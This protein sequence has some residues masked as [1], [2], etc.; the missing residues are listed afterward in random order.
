[1]TLRAL[2]LLSGTLLAL[3][4][5]MFYSHGLQ[6]EKNSLARER[7]ALTVQIKSRDQLIGQL[8][9][10]MQQREQ[11]ELALR[12]ALGK[13]SNLTLQR[14]QQFQRSH[15]DNPAVK[16]WAESPLPAAVNQL[17]QR[18]D[19]STATDYLRWLSGSQPLLDTRQPAKK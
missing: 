11:A 3:L 13:A 10:Q 8:S 19:F 7:D 17:H 18:P 15:N 6:Q 9:Q 1:M 5:L 12:Q 2:L 4:I 14:E 16:T